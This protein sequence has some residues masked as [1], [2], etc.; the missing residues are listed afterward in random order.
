MING[1]A[2]IVKPD[3]ASVLHHGVDGVNAAGIE[4]PQRSKRR[5]VFI[6][7]GQIEQQI[8][9]GF[10]AAFDEQRG[11]PRAYAVEIFDGVL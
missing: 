11:A 10:N 4:L 7:K 9:H 5:A 3:Q 2:L 6:A 1:G 8:A